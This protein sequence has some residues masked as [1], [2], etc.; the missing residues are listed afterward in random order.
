MCSSIYAE[1]AIESIAVQ[2]RAECRELK[3]RCRQAEADAEQ[4]KSLLEL[5]FREKSRKTY[6]CQ[7]EVSELH[8]QVNLQD[9][10]PLIK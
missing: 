4:Q 7:Q 8:E 5:S 9:L 2:V 1:K 6:L 3:Q 10:L